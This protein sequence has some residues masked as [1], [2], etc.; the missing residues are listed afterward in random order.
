MIFV[1][2]ISDTAL[3]INITVI[4]PNIRIMPIQKLG[5]IQI[6]TQRSNPV[7]SITCNKSDST[8]VVFQLPLYISV[9]DWP[10]ARPP[11]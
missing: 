8:N 6:G 5:S 9:G 2:L 11:A 4:K 7:T 10:T 3:I 1:D